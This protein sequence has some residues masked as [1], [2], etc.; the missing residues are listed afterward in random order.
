MGVPHERE[1]VLPFLAPIL[2]TGYSPA[3]RF[4]VTEVILTVKGTCIT[5]VII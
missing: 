5:Y 1:K 3:G 4:L 2:P